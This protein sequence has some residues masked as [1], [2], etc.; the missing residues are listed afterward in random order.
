MT[1]SPDA[2]FDSGLSAEQ[3]WKLKCRI[4]RVVPIELTR[5]QLGDCWLPWY[6]VS[7][8]DRL[9]TAAVEARSQKCDVSEAGGIESLDLDP[10]WSVAWRA[11]QGLEQF[12]G[13]LDR[14][15]SGCPVLELGCGSGQA[16]IGMALRGARVMMTDAVGLALLMARLNGSA[17]ASRL[18][19]R[20]LKWGSE[21]IEN[22]KFPT[23]IGSD[24]VYDPR[25]FTLLDVCAREHLEPGGRLFLS[26]PHRHTGDKFSTWIRERGWHVE[27]HDYDMQ[28]K[29][30]AI[31]VF[32][33]WLPGG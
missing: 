29:R 7:D 6:R 19:V 1:S 15:W 2:D 12:L 8:P 26:E 10:F 13:T 17:V 4:E 11:A 14:D 9:L 23:I 24:L 5:V 18:A 3:L 16:G 27:E 28:D 20:R 22:V 25:L 21:R 30:V 31:R 33:C 32:E